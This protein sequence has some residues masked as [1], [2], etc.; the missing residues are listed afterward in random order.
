MAPSRT[1]PNPAQHLVEDIKNDFTK[2]MLYSGSK[3]TEALCFGR[4]DSIYLPV[5]ACQG[6]AQISHS[7]A[8]SGW[9]AASILM[10]YSIHQITYLS[11]TMKMSLNAKTRDRLLAILNKK[12]SLSGGDQPSGT[13]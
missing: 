6:I 9:V 2:K 5:V 12:Y 1:Q 8:L 11:R 7:K 13:A 4:E 3:H 10:K